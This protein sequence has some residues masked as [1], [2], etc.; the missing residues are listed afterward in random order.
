MIQKP[1]KSVEF[2]ESYRSII[3]LPIETIC[4]ISIPKNLHNNGE[5]W[6]DSRSI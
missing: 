6:A 1:E 2:A 5:P 3:L 4:E